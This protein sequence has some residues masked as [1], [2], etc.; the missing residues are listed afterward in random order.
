LDLLNGGASDKLCSLYDEDKRLN[1]K[2]G[3]KGV[4][5]M[6]S[7]DYPFYIL[8]VSVVVYIKSGA[9]YFII[10]ECSSDGPTLLIKLTFFIGGDAKSWNG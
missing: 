1:M 4:L 3:S 10:V 8:F 9:Y 7:P 5:K 2:G 6:A